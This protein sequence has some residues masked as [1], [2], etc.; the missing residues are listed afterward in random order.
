MP[1]KLLKGFEGYLITDA[2][3]AY[4]KVEGIKR[5][6]YWAHARRYLSESIPLDSKGKEIPGSKGAEGR[7]YINLLFKLEEK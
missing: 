5:S 3:M 4:E 1:Q 7:E 2:Y 6:L